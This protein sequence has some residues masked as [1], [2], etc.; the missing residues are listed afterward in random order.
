MRYIG[1]YLV[2]HRFYI[3]EKNLISNSRKDADPRICMNKSTLV[4][5]IGFSID[6]T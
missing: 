6:V 5:T 1:K 3:I 4:N 2:I